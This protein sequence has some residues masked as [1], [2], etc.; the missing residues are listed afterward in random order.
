MVA[1]TAAEV[2][3]PAG[4]VIPQPAAEMAAPTTP[5]T[6]PAAKET[7]AVIRSPPINSANFIHNTGFVQNSGFVKF[8]THSS[9]E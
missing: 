6:T 1:K 8:S 3:T 2:A 7:A 5:A 4:I 9:P